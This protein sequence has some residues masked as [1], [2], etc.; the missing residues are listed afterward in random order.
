[1][2]VVK[3]VDMVVE[4]VVMVAVEILADTE[5]EPVAAMGV[6]MGDMVVQLPLYQVA[7][8]LPQVP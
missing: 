6:V 1:M 4:M 7:M 5:V 8:D 3:V 2:A